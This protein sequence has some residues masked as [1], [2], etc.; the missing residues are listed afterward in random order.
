MGKRKNIMYE[1]DD[2]NLQTFITLRPNKDEILTEN[3]GYWI[4]YFEQK[5]NTE[6]DAAIAANPDAFHDDLVNGSAS[7]SP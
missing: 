7:S 1:D 4:M 2:P 3:Q 5:Y 6:L